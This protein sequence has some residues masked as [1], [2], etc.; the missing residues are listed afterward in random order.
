M[1]EPQTPHRLGLV[2]GGSLTG[3]LEVRLDE[4]AVEEVK[5]GRLVAIDG[6]RLCFFGTITDVTLRSTDPRL[7]AAPPSDD[8]PLLRAALLGTAAYAT[9]KVAPSL[10]WDRTAESELAPARTVPPHFAQVREANDDDVARVFGQEDA[11]H[12]Y[13]GTPL[14]L[15]SRLCL[16]LPRFAQRSNGVFGR[17]GT[18]KTFLT[19]LLLIGLLQKGGAVN[20]VFDMHNEY[21]WEGTSE[22][23]AGKVKGLKQLFAS[24][25]AVFTVDQESAVRRGVSVDEVVRIGWDEIEPQD[26]ELLQETLNLTEAG[27]GAVYAMARQRGPRWLSDF[28][29]AEAPGER[30]DLTTALGEHEATIAALYRR[31]GRLRDFHFLA[32]GRSDALQRLLNALE[33]GRHVVLEFGRYSNNLTAYLL[34]ANFLTRRVHQRWVRRTEEALGDRAQE[35]PQLVITLEEA[36]RFLSPAIA[37]RT[38]FGTIAREMRKYHATLL[39]ID[40]RPS[41]IDDEVLS[42]LGTKLCYRLDDDADIDAVLAG[43]A[44][45]S[46]LKTV[47]ANLDAKQ[48]VLAFGDALPMPVVVRVREYGSP[49][50]YQELGIESE[51]DHKARVQRDMERMFGAG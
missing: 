9:V 22:G 23:P 24:K 11:A 16:D 20:L 31:L 44:G 27:V 45:R 48:Q 4:V 38:I 6:T 51:E 7:A 1:T 37:P 21:G 18:G 25:V 19:R 13:I 33:G 28:L 15:E 5:V 47:L 12:F 26:I 35:P 49:Q 3:G 8:E 40:Q 17:S 36:H 46:D 43:A 29:A 14:E 41:G 2:V 34:V 10:V 50:S 42:Q 30:A 32:E 39:V